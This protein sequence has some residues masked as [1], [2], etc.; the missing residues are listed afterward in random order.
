MLYFRGR[1][2]SRI[3]VSQ[4]KNRFVPVGIRSAYA[5]G[6]FRIVVYITGDAFAENV[7]E[8]RYVLPN[9]LKFTFVMFLKE[10]GHTRATEPSASLPNQ[11]TAVR[12]DTVTFFE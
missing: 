11:H 9:V 10:I 8:R 12:V 4:H 2:F 7:F 1:I 3:V 6:K 5:L